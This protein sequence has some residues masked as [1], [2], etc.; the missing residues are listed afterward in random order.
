MFFLKR[1]SLRATSS[2]DGRPWQPAVAT[3]AIVAFLV[4]VG[5]EH[6]SLRRRVPSFRDHRAG[7]VSLGI[8]SVP[9]PAG[10]TSSPCFAPLRTGLI[11][12]SRSGH[13]PL[14]TGSYK[15][16]LAALPSVTGGPG[17]DF[18]LAAHAALSG[19]GCS[20]RLVLTPQP[21]LSC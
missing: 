6:R 1:G 7:T 21:S 8:Y 13:Q 4:V 16:P 3:T 5:A 11:P 19:G 2:L 15:I 17:S 12:Y 18:K 10:I 20:R 9:F 14:R